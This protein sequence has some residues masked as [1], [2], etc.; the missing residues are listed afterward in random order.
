MLWHISL[1]CHNTMI[2]VET[3]F[4]TQYNILWYYAHILW[5]HDSTHDSSQYVCLEMC[6]ITRDYTYVS[7]YWTALQHTATH[8]NTLQHTA[9]HCN[10]LQHTATH[11]TR[12]NTYVSKCVTW[13][14][15][16]H[17]SLYVWHDSAQHMCLYMCDMT[18]HIKCAF[19]MPRCAES[20]HTFRD[21]RVVLSHVTLIETHVLCRVMSHI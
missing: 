12:H 19:T 7:T 3:Q 21:T 11:I 18:R 17:V 6:D 20:C 14:S 2:C 1:L 16:I 9:T 10:T 5:C 8:C 13:L 15:T 4:V